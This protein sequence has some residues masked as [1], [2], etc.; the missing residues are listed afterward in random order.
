MVWF[1]T[2][3]TCL[4]FVEKH[5]DIVDKFLKGFCGRHR[6]FQDPSRRIHQDHQR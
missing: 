4:N 2:V 3:S 1:T 6:L 5:P